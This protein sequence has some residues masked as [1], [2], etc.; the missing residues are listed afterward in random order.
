MLCHVLRCFCVLAAL[1]A[2]TAAPQRE[3]RSQPLPTLIPTQ[4]VVVA[5][6]TL[7]QPTVPAPSD[8][9]WSLTAPGVETRQLRFMHA[10]TLAQVN[11]VRLDPQ[12]LR[13]AVGYRPDAPTD[14]DSW[15]NDS[16]ALVAING[17]FFDAANRTVA[18][19]I[20]DGVAFGQSYEGRGGMFTA[21]TDGSVSLRYLGSQPYDSAEVLETA[22]Q[23]WPMLVHS[24]GAIYDYEDGVRDRR[25]VISYDRSGRV[26]LIAT[27]TASFTLAEMARWLVSA[28][29][30][31]DAALNLDGGSS[32]ALAL[33][34]SGAA[35]VES[36]LPLPIVLLVF[37]RGSSI[38]GSRLGDCAA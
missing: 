24:G 18:L 21:R 1:S 2:C 9:G 7:V 15:L 26:L 12:Q 30:D 25:S 29:L 37:P 23:G 16:A 13:F 34:D 28:D 27:P 38:V 20:S 6:T 17:G 35:R 19:I 4:P 10:E 14:L 5:P 36:F 32:T 31:L 3:A 33:N 8:S 22:L 11:V